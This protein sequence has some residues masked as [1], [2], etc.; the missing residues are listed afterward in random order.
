MHANNVRQR[1]SLSNAQVCG[2][3]V[4][5]GDKQTSNMSSDHSCAV[6]PKRGE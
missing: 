4:G 3:A 5:Q 2:R 1:L 6:A